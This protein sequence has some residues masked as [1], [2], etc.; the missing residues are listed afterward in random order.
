M[1]SQRPITLGKTRARTHTHLKSTTCRK[2]HLPLSS[3][4]YVC[5]RSTVY[6]N[7]VTD[8]KMV[9]TNNTDRYAI[10]GGIAKCSVSRCTYNQ[11]TWYY[12]ELEAASLKFCF[13]DCL[14]LQQNKMLHVNNV[15]SNDCTLEIIFTPGR[16]TVVPVHTM[17]AL[18]DE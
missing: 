13:L 11:C 17:T 3:L 14:F 10:I 7:Y 4:R 6:S 15:F 8:H 16:D 1:R 9:E 5:R 2:L 18:K 12:R